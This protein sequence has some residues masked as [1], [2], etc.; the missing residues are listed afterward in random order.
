MSTLAHGLIDNQVTDYRDSASVIARLSSTE[1]DLIRVRDYWRSVDSKSKEAYPSWTSVH[2]SNPPYEHLTFYGPGGF[3]LHFG[4]QIV[5][6]VAGCRYS[7]F[8]TIPALQA[9]HLPAFKSVARSLGG[10]RLVLMPEENGPIWDAIHDGISLENCIALMRKKWGDPHQTV[11]VITEDVKVYYRRKFPTRYVDSALP[12]Q[13][14]DENGEQA[15]P[16]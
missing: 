2:H 14:I 3:S 10:T 1:S 15:S 6:I 12:N 13:T 8:V 4:P 9:A 16:L 5:C 11:E 7:G